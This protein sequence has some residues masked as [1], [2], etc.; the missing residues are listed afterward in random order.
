MPLAEKKWDRMSQAESV[1]SPS[2]GQKGAKSV[3][4]HGQEERKNTP[5]LAESLTSLDVGFLDESFMPPFL[6]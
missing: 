1:T 6:N 5:S 3:L 4:C 2:Q